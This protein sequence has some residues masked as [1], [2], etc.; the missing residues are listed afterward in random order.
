MKEEGDVPY[1]RWSR[2][3]SG[4]RN[5]MENYRRIIGKKMG[6][7]RDVSRHQDPTLKAVLSVGEQDSL[8]GLPH[9]ITLF[10]FKIGNPITSYGCICR[11]QE[12]KEKEP[13][14]LL[15]SKNIGFEYIDFIAGNYR[16]SSLYFL[17]GG[18]SEDE[19]QRILNCQFPVLWNDLYNREADGETFNYALGKFSIIKPF[20]SSLFEIL[21]HDKNHYSLWS[22]PKGR[23]NYQEEIA[24]SPIN[25]ALREF[26]EETGGLEL[27]ME[28]LIRSNPIIERYLGSNSKNYQ[29]NYFIFNSPERFEIPQLPA[30]CESSQVKWMTMSQCRQVLIEPR[31]KIIEMVE[32]EIN[33]LSSHEIRLNPFWKLPDESYDIFYS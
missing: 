25:C 8:L 14:Y 27:K 10:N 30:T 5:F 3:V 32:E 12:D 4:F 18:L 2:D 19:R 16:D 20:L 22:F 9:R 24:E 1:V 23:V 15:V 17:L 7:T 28:Y 31:L 11:Y 29:T 21:P 13:E 6:G 33:Q 26:S